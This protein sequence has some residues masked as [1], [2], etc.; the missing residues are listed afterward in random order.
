MVEKNSY[1]YIYIIVFVVCVFNIV[2][3]VE[4]V[5]FLW[6]IIDL[7]MWYFAFSATF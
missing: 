4:S 1:M 2:L 7:V 3:D 6:L 5:I